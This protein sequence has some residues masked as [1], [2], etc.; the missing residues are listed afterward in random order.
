[1]NIKDIDDFEVFKFFSEKDDEEL[2]YMLRHYFEQRRLTESGY[3]VELS[4][5]RPT[6]LAKLAVIKQILIY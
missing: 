3:A 2:F 6:A 5:N 4:S 1:M